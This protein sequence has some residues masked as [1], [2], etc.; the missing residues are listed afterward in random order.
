MVNFKFKLKLCLF[1]IFSANQLFSSET[2]SGCWCFKKRKKT[3]IAHTNSDQK[4]STELQTQSENQEPQDIQ[5]NNAK[6]FEKEF[7]IYNQQKP[8]KEIIKGWAKII[9][10]PYATNP[11]YDRKGQIVEVVGISQGIA[12]EI[13]EFNSLEYDISKPKNNSGRVYII[14]WGNGKQFFHEDWLEQANSNQ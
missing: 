5:S 8:S 12:N 13:N 11:V 6:E 2:Q 1:Y 9:E 4:Q 7:S 3:N 10:D 14:K